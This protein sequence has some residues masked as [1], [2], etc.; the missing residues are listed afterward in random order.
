MLSQPEA[1]IGHP[2]G[3][4]GQPGGAQAHAMDLSDQKGVEPGST[5]SQTSF[6]GWQWKQ[7]CLTGD[8]CIPEAF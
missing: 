7:G 8:P 2:V 5:L 3:R 6:K 4:Q 1:V